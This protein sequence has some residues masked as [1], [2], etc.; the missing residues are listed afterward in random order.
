MFSLQCTASALTNLA[1]SSF[2]RPS[3]NTSPR[4]K[5]SIIDSLL[6]APLCHACTAVTIPVALSP[7]VLKSM[8]KS[9]TT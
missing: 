3:G 7:R 2:V 5:V 4:R 1:S 8:F 9:I 6:S